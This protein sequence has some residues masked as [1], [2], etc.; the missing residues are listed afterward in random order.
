MPTDKVVLEVGGRRIERWL[1]YEINADL[2]VADKAFSLEVAR[3]EIVIEPG[4]KCEMYVN[5]CLELTGIIDSCKRRSGKDG[6]TYRIEGRD[7]MGLLVDHYCEEFI[8]VEGLKLSKLA[9]KLLKDVPFINRKAITY[10]KD[11]VGKMKGK[12][13][14]MNDPLDGYLDTPQK[15]GQIQPG[16]TVFETLKNYAASRGLMFWNNP[17]GTFV[18]GQPKIGGEPLY[19][20]INRVKGLDNN[21]KDGEETN[22]ISKRYSKVVV[23]GQQQG[24]DE[25][26]NPITINTRG[27]VKDDEFPYY[28]PYVATDN[29]DAQ[30]PALHARYLMEQQRH[31]GY[32]LSYTVRGHSQGG[33]NWQINELC[34]VADEDLGIDQMLL[35]YSRTFKRSKTDGTTTALKLG[36]PGVVI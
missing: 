5:D 22:D 9:E 23:I 8:T 2:Y 33:R 20:L 36:K 1:S 12:K 25:D 7:L 29:N 28:K 21:A 19:E 10:Q 35:I 15:I 34:H 4:R 11:I 27:E 16:M 26:D 18:F 17:N 24:C 6:L 31:Q 3:P 13:K 30:S 32:Q 14:A